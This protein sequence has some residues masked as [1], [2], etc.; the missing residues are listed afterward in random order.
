MR[1]IFPDSDAHQKETKKTEDQVSDSKS[2]KRRGGEADTTID[3]GGKNSRER[4][5]GPTLGFYFS[6]KCVGDRR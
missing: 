4:N 5:S 3:P 2:A 1:R 6:H